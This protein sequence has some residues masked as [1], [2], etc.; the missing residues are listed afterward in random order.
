MRVKQ[1]VP[2]TIKTILEQNEPVSNKMNYV[3]TSLISNAII[4][5]ITN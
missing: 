2:N 1:T 3:V 5:L 4:A